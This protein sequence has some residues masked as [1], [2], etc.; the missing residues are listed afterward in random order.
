MRCEA[1]TTD[2]TRRANPFKQRIAQRL[3]SFGGQYRASVGDSCSDTTPAL[4][5][6]FEQERERLANDGETVP[7]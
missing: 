5:R 6:W 1:T 4:V 7:W 2:E 3:A